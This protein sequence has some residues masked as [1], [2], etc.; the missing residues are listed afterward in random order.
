LPIF[1]RLVRS[2]TVALDSA[3]V[4]PKRSR[5]LRAVVVEIPGAAESAV[6]AGVTNGERGRCA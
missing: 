4:E 1:A 3:A 6:S 2:S 5:M